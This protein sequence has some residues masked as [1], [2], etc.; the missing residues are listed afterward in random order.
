MTDISHGLEA[1]RL[2][3]Q[4]QGVGRETS[5]EASSPGSQGLMLICRELEEISA[6]P[7]AANPIESRPYPYDPI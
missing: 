6:L 1:G 3:G 2:G 5:F 4:H 7:P